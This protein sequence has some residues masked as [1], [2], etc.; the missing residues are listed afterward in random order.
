MDAGHEPGQADRLWK[1]EKEK[2]NYPLGRPE[3]NAALT[4]PSF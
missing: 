3:R 4:I 1:L 2:M